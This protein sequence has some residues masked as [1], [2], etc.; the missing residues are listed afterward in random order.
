MRI[1]QIAPLMESVPPKVYG[2]TERIVS[3]LT[4]ELVAHGHAVTLFASGDSRTGAKLVPI[5]GRGLR[6]DA[7]VRDP[8]AYYAILFD[9]LRRRADEFDILHFHIDYMHFPMFH[10]IC[11]R[12]VTTLHGRQDLPDLQPLYAAFSDMP[13]ISISHDQRRP[14]PQANWVGNVYHGLPLNLYPLSTAPREPYLAFLGRLSPEKQPDHAIEISRRSRLGLKLAAKIDTVDRSYFEE[15]IKPRLGEPG[16]EFVGEIGDAEKAA[17]LGNAQAL[18]FPIDWP[19]PFG[20]VMIEAMACGTPV[21]AYRRGSVPEV[22]DHGVSGFVV[23]GIDEA[24]TA[25][26]HSRHIDRAGVRRC[27]ERRFGVERMAA[28]YVEIYRSVIEVPARF[29]RRPT[30]PVPSST[31]RHR[32]VGINGTGVVGA[33]NHVA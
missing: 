4:E 28:E 12:T 2:G 19:E 3:Y 25:V 1:A 13:M 31:A 5:V 29:D 9:L 20:L 23:D 6:L 21:I 24:V 26:E 11:R 17:F 33:P 32:R 30:S 27:F 16:I 22:V 7:A 18:L 14:L 8:M 15:R 10:A